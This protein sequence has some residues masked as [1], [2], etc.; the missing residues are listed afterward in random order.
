MVRTLGDTP[1][2]L[3][4]CRTLGRRHQHMAQC[5]KTFKRPLASVKVY[6]KFVWV[7]S[8]L[9]EMLMKK[10]FFNLKTLKKIKS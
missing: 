1:A 8:R 2:A 6:K 9:I 3:I 4:V 5:C 7:L 10:N